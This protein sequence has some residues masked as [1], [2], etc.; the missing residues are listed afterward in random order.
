MRK[1]LMA[2]QYTIKNFEKTAIKIIKKYQKQSAAFQ[3]KYDKQ[4]N[5]SI[6]EVQQ[7]EWN[8]L[9]KKSLQELVSYKTPTFKVKI[10]M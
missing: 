4:T 10:K 5:H 8:D 2:G 1:E 3:N 6:N 9:V 7:K